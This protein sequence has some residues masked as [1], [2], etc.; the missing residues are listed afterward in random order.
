ME[1][2]WK[3]FERVVAAIHVMENSGATVTWNEHINGRQFDVAIRFTFQFYDYLVLIECRDKKSRVKAEAV[4]A[5]VTKSRDAGANKAIIVSSSGFQ[6]GAKTIAQKHNIELFTLTEIHAMTAITLA[7]TIGSVLVLQP[8]GFWRTGTKELVNLSTNP[9]QRA[10]EIANIRMIGFGNAKLIDILKPYS[11][12]IAP[13]DIPGVPKFGPT[14]PLAT[15]TRQNQ[16]ITL[17]L[18]TKIAFPGSTTEIPVSHFLLSYWMQ[19]AQTTIPG[20]NP[21]QYQY[22][23]EQ[24][25][26][27]TTINAKELKLGFET[28]LE[29]GKYYF[30]PQENAPY[31]CESIEEKGALLFLLYSYQQGSFVQGKCV[32]PLS[33]AGH[34]FEIS[35]AEEID[36]L[37]ILYAQVKAKEAEFDHTAEAQAFR[38]GLK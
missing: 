24:T 37:K 8:I 21:A 17:Q 36:K 34:F 7:D 22:T 4:E 2:T 27:T 38:D 5:F 29:S 10:N 26:K 12:L 3:K 13:F 11:Q 16:V 35:D 18:G 30:D 19:D 1:K 14:F 9:T 31:Y 28:R 20:M 25:Q 32:V 15:K 23:N 6:S 33:A